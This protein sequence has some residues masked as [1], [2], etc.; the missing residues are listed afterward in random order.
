METQ[1]RSQK[2]ELQTEEVEKSER[3]KENKDAKTSFSV[4]KETDWL[5][6]TD[7]KKIVFVKMRSE[8]E[9]SE[10]RN[11]QEESFEVENKKE[12][13]LLPETEIKQQL[14]GQ[15]S[16]N[17]VQNVGKPEFLAEREE[18]FVMESEEET[19]LHPDTELKQQIQGQK[20]E[21]QLQI[22]GKPEFVARPQ[23]SVAVEI[24]KETK[25]LPGTEIKQQLKDQKSENPEQKSGLTDFVA[26][27]AQPGRRQEELPAPPVQQ[28][29]TEQ[30]CTEA[31]P[32]RPGEGPQVETEAHANGGKQE[33]RDQTD[34]GSGGPEETSRGP[35][36]TAG[37]EEL[38][39]DQKT[40]ET[41]AENS[42]AAQVEDGRNPRSSR[43]DSDGS[44]TKPE[45]P[46]ANPRHPEEAKAAAGRHR[47]L[48]A[49]PVFSPVVELESEDIMSSGYSSLSTKL[50]FKSSSPPRED[51]SK[52]RFRKVSL[53][54]DGDDPQDTVDFNK[55]ES[56][57]EFRWKNRF[58]GVTQFRASRDQDFSGPPEA[59]L[60][61][62]SSSS[63]AEQH[64]SQEGRSSEGWE[65]P[66]G[67]TGAPIEAAAAQRISDRPE[68]Q[69]LPEES[70]FSG[71]F[72]ATLVELVS[73]PA[74]PPA[75]PEEEEEE[76]PIQSD[77]DSLVDTLRSMGPSMRPRTTN[78]VRP[79]PPQLMSSLPPIV[80][81]APSPVSADAPDGK[82]VLNGLY[83]LP[84]DLGLRAPRESRSPLELMKQSQDQQLPGSRVLN[85]PLRGSTS[86]TLGL[87]K[88]SDSSPEDLQSTMLN[89]NGALPSSRLDNSV[90]F[91]SY[92]SSS[93]DQ[94]LENGKAHRPIFRTGSLPETGL[95]NDRI[96][97]S[98]KDLGDPA[99]TRFE[100]FAFLVNPSS[101]Q[102]GSL[103][104]AEDGGRMSRPPSLGVGSPPHSNSPTRLLSPT[105]SIDLHRAFGVPESPLSM[106]TPILQ[107]S[108]SS[109]GLPGVQ[110]SLFSNVHGGSQFQN[111]EP[112]LDRNL[113]SK[114]R[115]FPDAYLTKE[116]EHG[117]LNPRPGKMY[118]FDRPGMC[119]QRFEVRSDV[120]D[121]TPWELQE[122]ISIRVVRGG[123]VLYEKP[124]FKGEKIALDEGDIELT[125]PYNLPEE[126]LQNGQKEGGQPS[127]EAKDEQT[128]AKPARKFIIG[129]IRRAV[130]DYSVPEISLFPEENAEG[131]KVIFRDTSDDA[132]I[133]GFPIKANSIIIN[134]GLWLVYAQ[135]FFQGVPRVL[136]VGGYTN[137]AAWG[138]EQ[139]YVGSLHPLKV[140]EPRV[141]NLSEPKIVIY[142]K[143]YFSGKSRTI[144]TNM[145]DFMTRMDRQQMVFMYNV[146]SLKVLGGIWVGYEKEG[147]RG[148]QYLLEEGEYHD[149]RVWGGIDA[150]LRSV[151]LIRADLSD[152]LL[153][154]FEQPEEEQDG[155]QNENTFEVTEAIPD[156]ELFGYKTS[157]RSI[158]VLSGAWIAY[159]HVDFSGNQYILEKGFYNNCADWG[160]VDPRIC[161][162]QPILLAPN[163]SS[164]TRNEII[165][166]SE[167]DF[168]GQCHIMDRN[169]E[170]VSETVLTK[171]CR[172]SGGS[173]VLYDNKQFS[174]NMYV[175]S[176][177]DYPS[178]SSM[179]CPAGCTIRSIKVVPMMFSLPSIS[180]FGLECLEGREI[181][182]DTEIVSLVEEGFNNHILSVRVNSGCWVICEHSNYRGRQF[183]L[184]PI[185]ITNWPKFSSMQTI[186]SM[187]PIRQVVLL[188]IEVKLSHS[189]ETK[190]TQDLLDILT[191]DVFAC[192][193]F[194]L[195]DIWE[196]WEG[197][198]QVK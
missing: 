140:G 162:V 77:M 48:Q 16:E 146:G 163:D 20:S 112:E 192:D 42:A 72:K 136:E 147:F 184:E 155:V 9:K 110:T 86:N 38:S 78:A 27:A 187:Y 161:S 3:K 190:N 62:S 109:E 101:P 71:V 40:K 151:R 45:Q 165:L 176:E 34:G 175:L 10:R 59:I 85:L 5:P 24:R 138:V 43:E 179:G 81:D 106:T 46:A 164:K 104:G 181:T 96:S 92:R 168:E 93:I 97:A 11:N 28:V 19:K 172:V 8:E 100:R 131:K 141:E 17:L 117:K 75:S 130:R 51:E 15:K 87:R 82:K 54:S 99:G 119:G 133:F 191:V 33:G 36:V 182:T 39:L 183:L 13:K 114:Y 83:A 107:R 61:L 67:E 185:E 12:T 52:Q 32:P 25:L 160:S 98:P 30:V 115:A 68:T 26:A 64:V 89:G 156:V 152:P 56:E 108:F 145:R 53:V 50:S 126:E 142:D 79:A 41:S 178:L 14:Q 188:S 95:S 102:S 159:S 23:E 2:S 125:Y 139:P 76:S 169:Q 84:A 47:F 22:S 197:R 166:Y 129:S 118:I 69:Q 150:E 177:G 37:G 44:R 193:C 88:L 127:G 123:W 120:V 137:P 195:G 128:E 143:P 132:R 91:G 58:E 148:N 173:W 121:A 171:S 149:W 70:E 73:D 80:E 63:F 94:T 135:P 189:E 134:A 29:N 49:P 194:A 60:H 122:T 180:M 124:N 167:P 4:E 186:G 158:H 170:A 144:S 103:T 153:V 116:K 1:L 21:I 105:G 74:A 113:V 111:Q 154:M 57:P 18:T 65:E 90:L 6:E 35:E 174:G 31:P 196:V 55:T 157:T 198:T 7:T 66:A